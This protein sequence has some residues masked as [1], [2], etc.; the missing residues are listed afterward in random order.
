MNKKRIVIT[1]SDFPDLNGVHKV[2][3]ESDFEL[4]QLLISIWILIGAL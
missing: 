4:V 2:F 1:D 3:N